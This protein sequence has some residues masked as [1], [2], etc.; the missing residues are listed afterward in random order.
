MRA[1]FSVSVS[2]DCCSVWCLFQCGVY[3]FQCGLYFS[4]VFISVAGTLPQD[5]VIVSADN[6][7]LP[8]TM[9]S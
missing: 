2:C 5:I 3:L 1:D 6:S 7:D 4:V 8:L 9:P